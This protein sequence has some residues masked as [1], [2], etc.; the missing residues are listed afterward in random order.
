[1]AKALH[2]S[3]VPIMNDTDTAQTIMNYKGKRKTKLICHC[4]LLTT[5]SVSSL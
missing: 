1:M 4:M 2:E 3:T 5:D